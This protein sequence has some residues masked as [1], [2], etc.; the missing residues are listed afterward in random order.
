MNLSRR[1]KIL[2][3]VAE[4]LGYQLGTWSPDAVDTEFDVE[5]ALTQDV[6]LV[7]DGD[8]YIVAVERV[9]DELIA[10]W[11]IDTESEQEAVEELGRI[12]AAARAVEDVSSS[13][14]RLETMGDA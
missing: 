10:G 8:Q 14:I 4:Y 9:R 2:H 6:S 5:E 3:N 1:S 11:V 13:V 12:V 7:E